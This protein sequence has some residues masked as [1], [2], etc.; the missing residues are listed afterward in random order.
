MKHF[1]NNIPT[2]NEVVV[3]R[4]SKLTETCLVLELLE[5]DNIIGKL[6]YVEL[7][8]KSLYKIKKN[9]VINNILLAQVISITDREISLCKS[10][11][12]TNY[13][14]LYHNIK[15]I[16]SFFD[17]YDKKMNT[18]YKSL[19]IYNKMKS[20][21]DYLNMY[22]LFYKDIILLYEDINKLGDEELLES[23]KKRFK[24]PKFYIELK[25]KITSD[26]YDGLSDIK[27][28]IREISNMIISYDNNCMIDVKF[29]GS[30]YYSIIVKNLTNETEYNSIEMILKNIIDYYEPTDSIIKF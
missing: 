2:I 9:F 20:P 3:T 17:Y 18:N 1:N 5:Y 21:S 16:V 26:K 24:L 6:F 12:D 23:I 15:K 14:D 27:N 29:I 25:Y 4:I 28:K 10:S 11:D 22:N 30:P 13:L 8:Y 19:Y 7:P